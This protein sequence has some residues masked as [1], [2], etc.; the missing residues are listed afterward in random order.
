MPD[1][2]ARVVIAAPPQAVFD[3][4][5]QYGRH[6]EWQPELVRAEV[7]TPGE[8]RPGTR[9]VE[10]RR[11][12][13]REVSAAYEITEHEPPRRSAFRTLDGPMR[14]SGVASFA[15]DGG[16]T[17]MTF[18]LDLNARGALRMLTPLLARVLNR[19]TR[20]HLERFKAIAERPDGG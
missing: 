20:A 16:G 13:G 9:G 17:R 19:Q 5:A 14:P 18:A 10:T 6:T 3:Y 4:Y 1:V 2:Q 8:V 11:M 7:T 12:L 15:P